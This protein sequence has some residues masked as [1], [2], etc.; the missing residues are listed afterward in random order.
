MKILQERYPKG[1]I[2]K[3]QRTDGRYINEYLYENLKIIAKTITNDMT[4]L[5]VI[6]SSTLEVGTGKSTFAQQ[7]GEAYNDLVFQYHGIK[8]DMTME[9]IVFKPK[10]LIERAF[11]LPKYSII[12]LDEWEDLHYWSELAVS[13]RHFFRKCR[14]LNL[15]MLIIIP[16]FFQL[17]IPYAITRSIF[18]IDVHFAEDFERGFFKFYNFNAKKD[19]YIKGKKFFNY[20]ASPP[21]FQGRFID[22]YV[23]NEK[24]YR[25]RKYKD[26]V[27]DAEEEKKLNIT[28]MKRELAREMKRYF[29]KATGF[30]LA[31]IFKV[32]YNTIY[33]W[34]K[35]KNDTDT[36]ENGL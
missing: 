33:E 23:V 21:N 5:G 22:G 8:L 9:N 13:L 19:L 30:Q 7:I 32:H 28:E 31:A 17:P 6:F 1:S 27:E 34:L 2:S 18:A 14:Q 15:F 26:M 4:F 16:N 10:E 36:K 3:Y 11:K 35:G 20:K 12:I 29:P 24:E 25:D